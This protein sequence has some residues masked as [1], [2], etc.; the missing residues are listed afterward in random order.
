MVKKVHCGGLNRNG[1]HRLMC[2][3]A[4]SILRGT[5]RMHGLVGVG[6][7]LLQK[8]CDQGL[9]FGF[10]KFNPALWLLPADQM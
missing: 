5:S 9:H 2:L 10:Q 1:P 6:V 8:V 4:W 7:V 3:N